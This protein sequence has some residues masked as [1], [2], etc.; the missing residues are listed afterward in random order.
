LLAAITSGQR[1]LDTIS[2]AAEVDQ[3]TFTAS[4]H[5]AIAV[6][7]GDVG[8]TGFFPQIQVL[9][10][11]N[12]VLEVAAG[13]TGAGI[14]LSNVVQSGTYTINVTGSSNTT[15]SYALSMF[16]SPATQ[17]VD[18]DSGVITSGQRV[19]G[20]V[21]LG[22]LDVYTFS[23]NAH[24][25]IALAV[26]DLSASGFFPQIQLFGPD[27]APL[28]ASAGQ[29][30]AGI[31][32]VNLT[33]TG[34]YSV[35]VRH[36]GDTFNGNYA[37][38]MFRSPSAQVV[39]ADSGPITSGQRLTGSIDLGDIDVYTFTASA[40]ESIALSIGDTGETG[41]F[42]QLELFAPDG[43]L[44][45]NTSGQTGTGQDFQNLN[46]T[47]TYYAVVRHAGDT[48]NGNYA[49]SFFR[50]P[51]TQQVDADSGPIT[52]GQRVTGTIDYGDLDVYTFTA[53]V[54][55]SIAL[56]VGDVGETSFFP[57]LQLF[58]PNGALLGTTTGQTGGGL[59]FANLAQTGTY[60]AVIR[61]AGD[62]FFGTYGLSLFR[63]TSTQVVDVDSGPIVSGQRVT[64]N[65]VYGDLDVYTF[66]AN[67]TE[68]I[69]LALGDIGQ[70]SFFPQLQIFAPNG[71]LLSNS[72]GQ[73]G[74]GADL[75]NLA[76]SGT[77]I[78]VV[79]HAG[80]TFVGSYALSLFRTTATQSV[81]ADSGP[82]VSS[83]KR[84]GNVD[85]GDLDI[86]T[87]NVPAGSAFSVA[88]ADADGTSF[89]PQLQVFGPNGALLFNASSQTSN[90]FDALN[91]P[92]GGTY[93][94][95]VRHA[96]DTFNGRYVIDFVRVAGAQQIDPLDNDGGA[97]TS[98]QS[99]SGAITLADMDVYTF[100]LTA[101]AN[102]SLQVNRLFGTTYNPRIDVFDPTGQR[103]ATQ[104]GTTTATVT[105]TNVR[106]AGTYYLVVRE[107]GD[108][109]VGNYSVGL[110]LAPA[111]DTRAPVV[112]AS[113]F[114]FDTPRQQVV[115]SMSESI[116]ASFALTDVTLTNLDT[117]QPVLPANL[118]GVFNAATNEIVIQ[119]TGFPFLA[120]PNG[121][122]RATLNA[123]SVQDTA[124]LP[125]GGPVS[126]DFYTLAGDAN[127]DR[128]VDVADLGILAS[129]WQ[130]P[131][132]TFSQGNFDYSGTGLV[133]VAD[134]GVLASGWQLTV[135]P[136]LAPAIAVQIGKG[137]ARPQR[138]IDGMGL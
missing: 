7:V 78:A 129:N 42:P 134:L 128:K 101:G 51:A 74:T 57:Q 43:T 97:I 66:T 110:D 8:A 132:R 14:D 83:Q 138:L 48:F 10:P 52:S 55:E 58:G 28:D 12:S 104:A 107:S 46:Q 80:D 49:L 67:A 64:G 11:D 82:L 113:R 3:Y 65:I 1:L 135:S 71:A 41:F 112:T 69:A 94:A 77:Y 45:G 38:T 22:D 13:Q 86:Y 123:G 106:L 76:Q 72:S 39:D 56:S 61:H 19:T 75:Q 115:F 92:T 125:F 40:S 133:D 30:G 99:R 84:Y 100:N 127:R 93:F 24:D 122:Y 136:P 108:D 70:T 31:D 120:L 36:A 60:Y 96:G 111:A 17:T 21:D 90:S 124:G 29:T 26:G 5:D 91:I 6:V 119:F 47:G 9:A 20:A 16:R 131:G 95:V 118:I 44:L 81:D 121:N 35:V 54:G 114:D 116:G 34:T 15:G 88:V 50:A 73:T 103:I 109:A 53:N 87:F 2:A 68:S 18:A 126:I 59:D 62:T 117:N 79:R 37:L 23:A 89:F 63:T 25:A 85:L 130:Q 102:A 137:S 105:L 32:Q 98:G 27:G 33:Q 4:A